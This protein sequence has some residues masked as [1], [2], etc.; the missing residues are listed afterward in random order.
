MFDALLVSP[1]TGAR[2]TRAVTAALIFHILLIAVAASRTA[3]SPTAVPPASRD[4]IRL[5]LAEVRPARR[6]LPPWWSRQFGSATDDA[7]AGS[8]PKAISGVT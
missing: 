2:W 8:L 1:P 5:D 4:T 7:A 6:A 3:A